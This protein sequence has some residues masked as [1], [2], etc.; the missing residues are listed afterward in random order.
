METVQ[1]PETKKVDKSKDSTESKLTEIEITQLITN[2][3]PDNVSD[4]K[5]QTATET[6]L[7]IADENPPPDY[8]TSRP[9]YNP[10]TE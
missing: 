5:K 10:S 1:M 9:S 8:W 2:P 3:L 6:T 7:N 4:K